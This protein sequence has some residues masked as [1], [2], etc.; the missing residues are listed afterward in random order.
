[1]LKQQS[2]NS[3]SAFDANI[4]R[5]L[6]RIDEEH[7]RGRFQKKP[8]GPLASYIK[9][10]D[11]TWTPAVEFYLGAGLLGA[12]ATDNSHDANILRAIMKEIYGGQRM[13][14]IIASKFLSQVKTNNSH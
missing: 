13:P 10:K 8:I 9:M 5:L 6:K 11:S 12:F 3:T 1:M 2:K 7:T 14:T 4:P